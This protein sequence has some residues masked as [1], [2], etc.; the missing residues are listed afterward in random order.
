MDLADDDCF[1]ASMPGLFPLSPFALDLSQTGIDPEL[2]PV[3]PAATRRER[4][5]R[6][7]AQWSRQRRRRKAHPPRAPP[8]LVTMELVAGDSQA[9]CGHGVRRRRSPGEEMPSELPDDIERLVL[10]VR[11]NPSEEY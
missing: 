11:R 2:P 1:F 6:G 5:E 7:A 9:Q 4:W 10:R 3:P 8:P